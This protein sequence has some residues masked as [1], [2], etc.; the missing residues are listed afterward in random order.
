MTNKN[1]DIEQKRRK[2]ENPRNQQQGGLP[3]EDTG[4][5]GSAEKQRNQQQDGQR[6]QGRDHDHQRR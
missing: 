3:Q 5:P 4:G 2:D 6:E 1:Q